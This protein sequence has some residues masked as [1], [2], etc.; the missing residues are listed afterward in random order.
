MKGEDQRNET[1][2]KT[3]EAKLRGIANSS[4]RRDE[5]IQDNRDQ[6]NN[7]SKYLCSYTQRK[8][9]CPREKCDYDHGET[10]KTQ[11]M[12]KDEDK[13]IASERKVRFDAEKQRET[14]ER[15]GRIDCYFFNR[16]ICNR[17]C[18]RFNHRTKKAE[19]EE[20]RNKNVKETHTNQQS[21]NMNMG[22]QEHS[23]SKEM[24]QWLRRGGEK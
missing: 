2:K 22:M 4:S 14:D 20:T 8:K 15:T 1:S 17:R 3:I 16:G 10:S 9:K 12:E 13:E 24:S 5:D 6:R 21:K 7:R 18:C 19:D 23:Q 11:E